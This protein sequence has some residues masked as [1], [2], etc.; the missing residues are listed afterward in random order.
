MYKTLHNLKLLTIKIKTIIEYSV[1]VMVFCYFLSS[2]PLHKYYGCIHMRTPVHKLCMQWCTNLMWVR[3]F[4]FMPV[5]T[6]VDQ[7]VCALMLHL[8]ND[9]RYLISK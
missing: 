1:A 5:T 2:P 3:D 8:F 7:K 9:I 6:R 4:M